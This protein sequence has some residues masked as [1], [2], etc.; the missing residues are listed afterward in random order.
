MNESEHEVPNTVLG[1]VK[2]CKNK[3]L[4]VAAEE[5]R[6][7]RGELYKDISNGHCN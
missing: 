5:L 6:K 7:R 3:Y 2:L 1:I 4:S